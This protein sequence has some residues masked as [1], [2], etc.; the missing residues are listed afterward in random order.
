MK[1]SYEV[2]PPAHLQKK[3]GGYANPNVLPE[4]LERAGQRT[5]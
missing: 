3:G 5:G 1:V 2:S 4:L